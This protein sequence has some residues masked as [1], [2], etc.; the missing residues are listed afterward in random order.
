MQKTA[1]NLFVRTEPHWSE[2]ESD[3]ERNKKIKQSNRKKEGKKEENKLK[4]AGNFQELC[5]TRAWNSATRISRG[6]FSVLL[7]LLIR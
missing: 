3:Y 1:K 2:K 4:N 6:N 5:G 7:F